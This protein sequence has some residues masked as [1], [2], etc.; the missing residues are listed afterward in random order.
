MKIKISLIDNDNRELDYIDKEIP[1][2]SICNFE[3]GLLANLQLLLDRNAI[4]NT[5]IVE[6][7]EKVT[8]GVKGIE[9]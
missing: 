8:K 6:A 4:D 1:L 3:I 7:F 5:I 2:W 9:L